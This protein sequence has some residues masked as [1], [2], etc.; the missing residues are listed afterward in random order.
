[1]T[2][3]V[4]RLKAG[5]PKAYERLVADYGDRL[6]RFA[7]RLSGPETAE[8]IVQEVFL[9]VY[10]S[11]RS[12]DPTG[13]LPAWIFTI[14]SNLCVD[15]LR[16]RPL[17]VRARTPE[18]DPSDAAV[19]RESRDSLLQAIASLPDSQKRVFLLRE[20]AGLTFREIAELL[21]C[22]LGT[23]LGRMHAAMETLRKSLNVPSEK[24]P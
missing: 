16:R 22:P 20:E 17:Q 5:D 14:A 7:S 9:R 8:D 4:G 11:V 19:R 24:R 21:Q 23:A 6:R 12:F 10:R 2:D 18:P 13:S 15:Q 3:F 1:M